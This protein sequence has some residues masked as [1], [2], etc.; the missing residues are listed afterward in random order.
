MG[1]ENCALASAKSN[2]VAV[3]LADATH[4]NRVAVL[5]EGAL[6]PV[7]K[8]N[9]ILPAPRY[10]DQGSKLALL[11]AADRARSEHVASVQVASSLRMVCELL[12]HAPMQVFEVAC[13]HGERIGAALSLNSN[14]QLNVVR[15]MISSLIKIRKWLRLLL[16]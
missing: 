1:W 7:G 14:V 11:G 2:I 5:E 9:W 10:F 4:N 8:L 16:G 6:V 12:V 15:V 13:R 3:A